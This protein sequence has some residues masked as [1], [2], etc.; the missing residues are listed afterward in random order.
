MNVSMPIGSL[1]FTQCGAQVHTAL[2]LLAK[3]RAASERLLQL[4]HV[5]LVRGD[6]ALHGRQIAVLIIV[7][8]VDRGALKNK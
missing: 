7:F 8:L 1:Y 4:Q 2:R 3:H 5:R 6:L